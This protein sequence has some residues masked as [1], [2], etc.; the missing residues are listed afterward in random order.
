MATLTNKTALVTGG[1]SGIGKAI[2]ERFAEEGARVIINNVTES[3][4]QGRGG[5]RRHVHPG[6]PRGPGAD[7]VSRGAGAAGAWWGGHPREQRGRSA[8][9]AH[10]GVPGGGVGTDAPDHAHCS[11]PVD[12]ISAAH[13]ERAWVGAHHQHVFGARPHRQ[14]EQVRLHRREAR[15]HR[16]HQSHRRGGRSA[17][18]HGQCHL[19]FVRADAAR[20]EPAPRPRA[21]GGR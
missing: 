2:A 15:H 13:D 5:Y 9:R 6:R 14:P 8:R 21:D 11:L 1:A 16:A 10:R 3:R 7:A 19:P 17:R 18:R 4:Q 20:R 12:E